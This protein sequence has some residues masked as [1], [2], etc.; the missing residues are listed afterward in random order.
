MTTK[1]AVL[2][3]GGLKL[4]VGPGVLTVFDFNKVD[5]PLIW[6][7]LTGVASLVCGW[8]GCGWRW[9]LPVPPTPPCISQ[10]ITRI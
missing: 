8:S 2:Q 10:I 9:V 1:L 6:V 7:E 4:A 3:L 5:V